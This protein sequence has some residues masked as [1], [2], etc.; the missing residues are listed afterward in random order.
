ML[1]LETGTPFANC[2]GMSRR[3]ALKARMLG[4]GGL[5]LGDLFKLQAQGA[6]T[7]SDKSIILIR[8]PSG[9][10]VLRRMIR[11]EIWVG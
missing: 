3:T 7:K 5:S 4:I 10:R 2:S 9:L 8:L 1:Q 6:A 11:A